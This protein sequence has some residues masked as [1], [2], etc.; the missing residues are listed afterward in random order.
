MK[1]CTIFLKLQEAAINKQA[2]AKRQ[3]YDGNT[4]NASTKD[5]QI[6]NGASQGQ[7]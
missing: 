5:Q 7:E 6:N 1:D 2:K 4:N 3:G